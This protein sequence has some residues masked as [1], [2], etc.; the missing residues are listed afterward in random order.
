MESYIALHSS[1][2]KEAGQH[3]FDSGWTLLEFLREK[4]SYSHRTMTN[5]GKKQTTSAVPLILKQSSH[6]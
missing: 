2:P 6:L 1:I 4:K 5:N 3:P